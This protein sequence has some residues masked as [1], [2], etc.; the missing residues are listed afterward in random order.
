M[1]DNERKLE[2]DG[3]L[4]R[5]VVLIMVVNFFQKINVEIKEIIEESYECTINLLTNIPKNHQV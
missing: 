5:K 1:I 4:K 3:I 2:Y